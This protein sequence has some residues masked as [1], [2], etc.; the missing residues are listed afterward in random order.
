MYVNDLE[1]YLIERNII[2]LRSIT[3]PIEDE[4]LLYLK[5]LF[6]AD[7]TVILVETPGDLQI[8]LNEFYLYCE[9]WKLNINL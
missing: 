8:P 7:D 6:Y 3:D 5:L 4:L 9:Q 1:Q 2:G